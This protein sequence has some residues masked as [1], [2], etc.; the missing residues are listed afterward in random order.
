[1]MPVTTPPRLPWFLGLLAAL[2]PLLFRTS[3]SCTWFPG[4]E[5]LGVLQVMEL[6]SLT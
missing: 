2:A 5:E 4:T 6:Q 3:L 1:M